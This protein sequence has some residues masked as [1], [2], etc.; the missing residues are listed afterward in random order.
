MECIFCL[1]ENAYFDGVNYVCPDCGREWPCDEIADAVF[2]KIGTYL[3]DNA[4]CVLTNYR[5]NCSFHNRPHFLH[6]IMLLFLSIK[7]HFTTICN[8]KFSL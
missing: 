1:N 5:N 7:L 8:L 6:E 2:R 3:C 4:Y